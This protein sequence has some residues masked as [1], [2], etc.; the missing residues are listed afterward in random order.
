MLLI[1]FLTTIGG[2]CLDAVWGDP[3]GLPHPVV[4]IGKIIAYLD[5]WLNRRELKSFFLGL[6]GIL[7][8]LITLIVAFGGVFILLKVLT[9]FPWLFWPVNCWLMGTT[10]ARKGLAQA[11]KTIYDYLKVGDLEQAGEEVGKIVGRDTKSLSRKEIIRATVESVAENSVDGVIAPLFFGMVGGAPLAMLY[12]AV[13]TL[14]SMLGYKN[15]RYQCFGW[16]AARLDDLANLLP[17]RICAFIMVV[18]SW[19]LRL[20]WS[21]SSRTIWRDAHK[22]PSPNGGWPEAAVAGALGVRLGG[23]NYYQGIASF[24]N[25]MGDPLRELENED[26]KRTVMILNITTL[27]TIILTAGIGIWGYNLC[28]Y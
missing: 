19:L 7:T 10:I 21:R 12:R 9:P 2:A 5:N 22:H 13:N 11:A 28:N 27:I 17:A 18:G 23:T 6:N 20:D 8:V 1:N 14:D 16:A 3:P 26:I 25:Y 15:E 24:R 4:G